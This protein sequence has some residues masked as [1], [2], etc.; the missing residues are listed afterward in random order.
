M[1][2]YY[3]IVIHITM[4]DA[5][6]IIGKQINYMDKTWVIKEFYYVPNNPNIY[7]QLSRGT[8]NMNVMLKDITE[9]ITKD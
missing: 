3:C 1:A 4:R 9:L 6:I 5:L 2:N 8:I 7:V